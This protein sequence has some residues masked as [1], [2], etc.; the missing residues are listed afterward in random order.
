MKTE[1]LILLVFWD[2]LDEIWLEFNSNALLITLHL[3]YTI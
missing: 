2:M 3:D 1:I